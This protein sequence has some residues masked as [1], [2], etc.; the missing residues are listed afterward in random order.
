LISCTSTKLPFSE[1][2]LLLHVR[3]ARLLKTA[4]TSAVQWDASGMGRD[5]VDCSYSFD[6]WNYPG[7]WYSSC[8]QV[9]MWA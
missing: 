2:S 9:E 1:Y 3:T 8:L 4:N 7:I 5:A 6:T